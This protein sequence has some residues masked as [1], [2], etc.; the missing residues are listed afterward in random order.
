MLAFVSAACHRC[1]LSFVLHCG[2]AAGP[3]VAAGCDTQSNAWL[4]VSG[5]LWGVVGG[6]WATMVKEP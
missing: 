3:S 2:A 1:E 5:L 4:V 6:G